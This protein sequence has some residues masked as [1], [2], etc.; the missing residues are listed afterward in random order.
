MTRFKMVGKDVNSKINQHR[1]WVV[2]DTP[3]LDG[4]F[5]TGLKSGNTPLVDIRAYQIQDGYIADFNF[6]E[7]LSWQVA[8]QTLPTG[9]YS[10]QLAIIDGYVYLFG[11]QDGY[12]IYRAPLDNPTVWEDTGSVLPNKLSGSQLAIVDGYAYLFGG[13][14]TVAVDSIYR[15]SVDNPLSWIDTGSNLPS[16]IYQSQL[17]IADGYM[18]L[19]GGRNTLSTTNIIYRASVT[20]PLTWINTGDVLPDNLYG[21]QLGLIDGYFY[22]F[23]GLNGVEIPTN[24]I[25]RASLSTPTSFSWGGWALPYSAGYGQFFTIGNDGY[26]ITA[27]VVTG[28]QPYLTRIFKCS[29]SDPTTWIDTLYTLPADISDSQVA[30]IY[31]RIFLFGG[32]GSSLILASNQTLKYPITVDAPSQIYGD[33]TRTQYQAT[34]DPLDLMKVICIHSWKTNY[35]F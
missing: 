34:L 25:Y 8:K 18:Y 12:G 32:N 2:D 14:S 7:A 15:A 1:T 26:L 17:G 20:D 23:G 4:Y 16:E 21:S 13:F 9:I 31:D 33:I 24:R 6:P 22:L 10:S 27:A 19:F 5:Y 28:S 11:R 30:I 3:D 35:Q 29:L